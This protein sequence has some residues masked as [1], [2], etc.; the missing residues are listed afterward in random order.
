MFYFI[1]KRTIISFFIMLAATTLMYFLTISSGDP[2]EDLGE[3]SGPEKAAT[4]AA[5]T[6]AMNL[7][8]P[9]I[10]RYFLWLQD[11]G[12]CLVPGGIS[13][14]LGQDRTGAAVLPQLENAIG[15][16][17]RLV[18]VATVLALV[19]GVVVGIVTAI[20]QYST[21]DY[22]VTFISFLLFS[23]PLF[24]L[25][26]LLKQ[27]LAIDLNTWLANPQFSYLTIA[28]IGVV[29]GVVWAIVVGGDRRRRL[30]VFG[31]AA[32]ATALALYLLLVTGWFVAP[33]F[34]VVG[35]LVSAAGIAVLW[36][37][38]LAGF[39]R[40]RV[41]NAALAA[42]GVSFVGY[43]V[44][45]P[46]LSDPNW[47]LVIVL[48]VALAVVSYVVAGVVGGPFRA[49][50][51]KIGAVIAVS[52]SLL[53]VLDRL[54]QAYPTLSAKAGGRPIPTTG[55]QS[56]NLEGTF[57]E[58]NL[59]YALHLILP[60]IALTLISFATYTRYT[61]ASQLDV[62][63]QD[64]I[65]TARAKGLSERTVLVKHAF[66]NAMIPITT[67]MAFDFAGVLGGAVITEQV[68]GWNGMGKMFVDG[69][70]N[71]D[72]GPVMAFFLVVGTAAVLFN[73]LADIAYA[74]LDPRITLS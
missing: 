62:M 26:T 72:P 38:L 32:V 60:T 5:R 54:L 14:T 19:L 31:I 46:L 47:F 40:R 52:V 6:A 42:A 15:S 29:A 66:R 34:G 53:I 73:M 68:F 50:A 8:V 20:R 7:D 23:L 43:L 56:A 24:W 69:I 67:L 64:Y 16:T 13:C 58:I 59:D 30:M 63:N 45:I 39:R 51:A 55:S 41:L 28:L 33:G 37:A 49:Q 22:S 12:H 1:A 2:F 57:W 65:R 35:M 44:S 74:F 61:R 70:A 48:V 9:P 71:V 17:L 3:T 21:F 36:T 25:S 27:Y 11:V 4:I 18:V 10:P